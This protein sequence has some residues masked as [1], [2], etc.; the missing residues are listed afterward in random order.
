MTVVNATS[1]RIRFR[2]SG[3]VATATLLVFV[4]VVP[5][6]GSVFSELDGWK[7]LA[8]APLAIL[9]MIVPLALTAWALRSGVDVT[10]E[11]LTVKAL[12]GSRRL[13][14][15]QVTG[16]EYEGTSAY[17]LLDDGARL[18]LPAVTPENLPQ[19]VEA[20]GVDSEADAEDPAD[21]Q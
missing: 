19:L 2:R 18:A 15:S 16:F 10:S 12:L 13:A 9:A 6:A 21:N 4:F 3:G 8:L 14:W 5:L 7:R 1:T 20:A 11:G 17:V